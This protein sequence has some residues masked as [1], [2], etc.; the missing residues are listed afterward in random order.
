[1][2]ALKAMK[3]FKYSRLITIF[4]FSLKNN[5]F[6]RFKTELFKSHKSQD[7]S[8]Y[9]LGLFLGLITTLI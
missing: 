6:F 3:F 4:I 2:N 8:K 5:N 9:G 7:K 1:M